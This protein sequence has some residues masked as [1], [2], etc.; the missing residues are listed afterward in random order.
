MVSTQCAGRTASSTTSQAVDGFGWIPIKFTDISGGSPISNLPKDPNKSAVG[1]VPSLYYVYL[2]NTADN[3]FEL[4]AN[5]ESTSY[6][7]T[8]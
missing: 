4:V 2:T 7:G 8:E 1:G 6:S 3:T 5:L